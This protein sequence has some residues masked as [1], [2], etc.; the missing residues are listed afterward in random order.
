MPREYKY[1]KLKGKDEMRIL[2]LMPAVS[3]AKEIVC[4]L[5]VF[6]FEK[7]PDFEALSWCWGDQRG[8]EE[9]KIHENLGGEVTVSSIQISPNLYDALVALRSPEK[10][11]LLWVDAVC[12]NQNDTAERN[13]Q[14]PQM[15]RIYGKSQETCI[16]LGRKDATSDGAINFIESNVLKLW[17]FDKL[18]ENHMMTTQWEALINLMRRPWFS[19]RWVVQEI[20]LSTKA[21]IY[22]GEKK[23]KWQDFA[24]AVSLFVEVESATHRLSDVMKRSQTYNHVPDFFGDVHSLGAAQLVDAT[25]NLFRSSK[26]ESK[27]TVNPDTKPP[28][29]VPISSLEYLVSRL[30]VFEASQ[31]HDTIYALLAIAK[32]TTPRNYAT[33]EVD[34]DA[35]TQK[36]RETLR[37]LTR[38]FQPFITSEAYR[39]DYDTPVRDA[40]QEFV[41]FSIEKCDQT[42]ALDIICRP[43]APESKDATPKLPSWIP[44]LKN[45]AFSTEEH[46]QS[47]HGLRMTR[48]NADPLVGLPAPEQRNYSAAGSRNIVKK[49]LR[50]KKRE[51]YYSMFAE[52]F[53]LDSI[54]HVFE[55][56]RLGN[57]PR[58]WADSVDWDFKTQEP[59]EQLWRTL[60]ADRG[61]KGKNP[62][63]YFPRACKEVMKKM[64]KGDMLNSGYLID[65]CLCTIVAEFLR[66]VQA[67]IWNR[68]LI[69][70]TEGRLGLAPCNAE[71]DFAVCIL[72]GCSVPVV[73]Q[74]VSKSQ[75]EIEDERKM[76]EEDLEIMRRTAAEKVQKAFKKRREKRSQERLKAEEEKK[77]ALKTQEEE[78]RKAQTT[79]GLT[80]AGYGCIIMVF[81]YLALKYF[82]AH[83]W[84]CIL[85]VSY[86]TV[87]I[88]TP[89]ANPQ[90][91]TP[92][93]N[94]TV[95]RRLMGLAWHP[96]LLLSIPIAIHVLPSI[97]P[98]RVVP[99][100]GQ[101][102][103]HQRFWKFEQW[104]SI[105]IVLLTGVGIVLISVPSRLPRVF[106]NLSRLRSPSGETVEKK[107]S[108][109][110]PSESTGTKLVADH[111][112]KLIGDCYI[113][114]MMNGDAIDL[115]NEREIKRQTFELR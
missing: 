67:V 99:N 12:I 36:S 89:T 98:W 22:C 111:Y 4:N 34:D 96:K 113:H 21:T 57:I 69:R 88:L 80:Y 19:R 16:W 50:F 78:R 90:M 49:A 74:K 66:R 105:I 62:P 1:A 37:Q 114:G 33:D 30:P 55:I 8:G 112:W 72:Y 56:A 48:Q 81:A 97:R 92:L 46:A 65:N 40:F 115:Q 91:G 24:D 28:K 14:V 11:R 43:W 102:L 71:K 31:A 20:A 106:E 58:D 84:E 76:D 6:P 103:A 13:E 51:Q 53:K 23:I 39:V 38:F 87:S 63:S 108:E 75:V 73:L 45:A 94:Q 41:R 70:T 110:A 15:D 7:P 95:Q 52:G 93:N 47:H 107:A 64:P 42:R 104:E 18:C 29:K 32:D 9:L 3:D 101:C 35:K 26:L 5:E 10:A 83:L 60:V 86:I 2:R 85:V 44:T 79:R 100:L 109:A 68:R 27:S 59:P 54:E 61:P 77:K 25:S 17:E 82:R